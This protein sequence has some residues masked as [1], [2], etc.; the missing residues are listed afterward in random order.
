MCSLEF[1]I[2]REFK[3]NEGTVF[4]NNSSVI[5]SGHLLVYRILL[6]KDG[7]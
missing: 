6:W 5:Q 3:G 7:K 2:G 4:L 1:F